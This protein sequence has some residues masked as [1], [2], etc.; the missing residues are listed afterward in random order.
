[1]TAGQARAAL[2][3]FFLL[4][5][6]IVINALYLQNSP[7][8]IASAKAKA[9]RAAARAQLLRARRL[10][11]DVVDLKRARRRLVHRGGR[12][13]LARPAAGPKKVQKNAKRPASRWRGET[14]P[15]AARSQKLS[16]FAGQ[17][18]TVRAI[19]RELT[20]RNYEPG[21]VDGVPGLV[22]RAAIMAYQYDHKLPVTGMPSEE[23]L[24]RII[25]GE[26]YAGKAVSGKGK[27]AVSS[28]AMDVTRTVQQSLLSLG[29]Q[30]GTPDGVVGEDT[31]RAIREFEMDY[32]LVP[33]GRVSGHLVAQ[34]ARLAGRGRLAVRRK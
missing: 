14:T 1:M 24:R 34:L 18:R 30:P 23:L 29:Y 6:G 12:S 28:Y 31:S 8:L 10:S 33:T 2:C 3:A 4:A 13:T 21:L 25:L 19:Q 5:A 16:A 17:T 11:V 22:T 26:P 9:A 32:G 27:A 15:I 20:A 7:E